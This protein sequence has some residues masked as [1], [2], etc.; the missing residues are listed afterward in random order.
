MRLRQEIPLEGESLLFHHLIRIS[1]PVFQSD[2][3]QVLSC[4]QAFHDNAFQALVLRAHEAALQVVKFDL[5]GLHI[6]GILQVKFILHGVGI[7]HI[8]AD[9]GS[10][11]YNGIVIVVDDNIECFGMATL[12]SSSTIILPKFLPYSRSRQWR[13]QMTFR[14]LSIFTTE[15][16]LGLNWLCVK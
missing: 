13:C 1:L 16:W 12:L 14:S 4:G 9:E 6:W 11:F 8:R 10:C 3:H 7:E 15:T 2:L 5:C